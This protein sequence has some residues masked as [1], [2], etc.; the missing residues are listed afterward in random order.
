LFNHI[1]GD[2]TGDNQEDGRSKEQLVNMYESQ[3]S[4]QCGIFSGLK[5]NSMKI[6]M[7]HIDERL[8]ML[9]KED[10]NDFNRGQIAAYSDLY[11]RIFNSI[12]FIDDWLKNAGAMNNQL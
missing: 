7:N 4:L 8:K 6:L 12:R 3:A 2:I 1:L 11:E 9:N 5:Y 10:N